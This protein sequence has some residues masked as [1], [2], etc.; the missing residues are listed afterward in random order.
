[1]YVYPRHLWSTLEDA[2]G[3]LEFGK[4]VAVFGGNPGERKERKVS[5]DLANIY[6][7][8]LLGTQVRRESK[9]GGPI[10]C[11]YMVNSGSLIEALEKF[12]RIQLSFFHTLS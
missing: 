2:A 6:M 9:T 8:T 3:I 5:L 12:R 7:S 1:M 11:C 10:S 4:S